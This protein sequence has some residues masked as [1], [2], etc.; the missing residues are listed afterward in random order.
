LLAQYVILGLLKERPMHG[1]EIKQRF[2]RISGLFW[3][4]SYGSLYPALRKLSHEGYIVPQQAGEDNAGRKVFHLTD[5]GENALLSW[6]REAG[7]NDGMNRNSRNEFMLRLTFFTYLPKT[8]AEALIRTRLKSVN[9]KQDELL[10][11][12][13]EI[14]R[15][16]EQGDYYKLAML[17]YIFRTVRTEKAWLEDLLAGKEM[18]T[19]DTDNGGY[20]REG[21]WMIGNSG[22]GGGYYA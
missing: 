3:K 10:K 9:C 20:M 14:H 2:E 22:A 8:E 21:G 15:R 7:N 16:N 18:P 17:E 19:A 5:A 11:K 1:Y 4:V 13:T 12:I 6:L